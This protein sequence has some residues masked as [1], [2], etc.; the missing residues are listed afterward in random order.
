MSPPGLR[1][2]RKIP[3][4]DLPYQLSGAI[5]DRL[6]D[7]KK[8]QAGTLHAELAVFHVRN[9]APV[10][11]SRVRSSLVSCF[12]VTPKQQRRIAHGYG[13]RTKTTCTLSSL[14]GIGK[15]RSPIL[16]RVRRH[17]KTEVASRQ[18]TR[19]LRQPSR[20]W[21]ALHPMWITLGIIRVHG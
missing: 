1:S 18:M 5:N 12:T 19:D 3:K 9:E 21:R 2:I 16:S 10:Y 7:R 4:T 11:R 14:Q 17:R 15:E 8:S 6:R 13:T 20:P